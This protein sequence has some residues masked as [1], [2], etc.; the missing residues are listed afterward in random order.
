MFS[1]LLVAGMV[2][3]QQQSG[4]VGWDLVTMW[5]NMGVPAKIGGLHSVHDV[6]LVGGHHD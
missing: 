3:F 6:R 2:M 1:N 4:E 5:H